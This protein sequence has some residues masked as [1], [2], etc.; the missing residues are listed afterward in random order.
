MSKSKDA[1][2]GSQQQVVSRRRKNRIVMAAAAVMLGII[3][4]LQGW[5]MVLITIGLA[6][7]LLCWWGFIGWYHQDD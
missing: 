5:K 7:G 4:A 2:P 6:I 3:G 1:M